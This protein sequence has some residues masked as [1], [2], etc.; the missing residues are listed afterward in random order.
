MSLALDLWAVS[1]IIEIE[2]EMCGPD[3]LGVSRVTDRTNPRFRKI[4]IPPMMDTQLDR[5]VITEVL[6]P[7]RK[8]L[9]DQFEAKIS[10]LRP[11]DW[12][13]IYLTAFIV[14]D[15][16]ERLAQHSAYHAKLHSMPVSG[17]MFPSLF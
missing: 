8:K 11:E 12:F 15:H 2:W 14:L 10:P 3:T 6:H 1:R 16:I 13:D 7:L 9:L 5:I 4:P 17:W